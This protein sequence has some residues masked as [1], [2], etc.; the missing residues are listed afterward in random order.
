MAPAA[1]DVCPFLG[2]LRGAAHGEND[3]NGICSWLSPPGETGTAK[4]PLGYTESQLKV[5]ELWYSRT[6]FQGSRVLGVV[7]S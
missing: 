4:S 1:I 2:P 5:R 7:S 3:D 6:S